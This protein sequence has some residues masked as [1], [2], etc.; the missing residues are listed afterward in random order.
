[1]SL[2]GSERGSLA[3]ARRGEGVRAGVNERLVVNAVIGLLLP[4]I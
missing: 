4:A 2:A 3:R 1:M